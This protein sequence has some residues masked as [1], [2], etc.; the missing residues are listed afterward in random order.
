MKYY[1]LLICI[2][3][4]IPLVL[5]CKKDDGPEPIREIQDQTPEDDKSLV[6]YLQTHFYNYED[7]ENDPHNHKIVITI[8]TIADENSNKIPLWDQVNTKTIEIKDKNDN[9]IPNKMYFLVVKEGIGEKPSRVDSTFVTYK[10]TLL[11]RFV[12]D[13]RDLPL[14]F[15]LTDVVRGF[16]EFLPELRSG[17]H[18][19]NN[20]GTYDFDHYGQE[21]FLFPLL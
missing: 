21:C 10:G 16:R 7:F 18:S 6:K 19:I 9:L 3:L 13:S 1:K 11:N 17:S 15:D 4:S 12:F 14:W 2:T 20:D 8:D 5:G